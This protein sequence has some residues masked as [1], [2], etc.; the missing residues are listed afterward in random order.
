MATIQGLVNLIQIRKE[1]REIDHLVQLISSH[2]KKLDA[3]LYQLLYITEV[4][5]IVEEP[6]YSFYFEQL[7]THLRQVIEKNSISNSMEL[8]VKAP[9]EQ[10]SGYNE[11]LIN[12]VLTNLILH[13]LSLPKN[14]S[15]CYIKL[16]ANLHS[17]ALHIKIKI[18][19]FIADSDVQESIDN[20][21]A[22]MYTNIMR[23]SKLAH[24]FAAQKLALKLKAIINIY[25]IEGDYQ[26]ISLTIPKT[27]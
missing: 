6:T 11:L 1:D 9:A 8:Y 21:G 20:S 18:K 26:Q 24:F 17:Q 14:N 27:R 22:S 4:D 2:A 23:Y 7:E 16:L 13:L 19:G 12:G 5:K 3:R 15:N 25:F 10:I